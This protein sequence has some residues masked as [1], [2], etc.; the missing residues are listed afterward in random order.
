MKNKHSCS[1][2]QQAI[3]EACQ[4]AIHNVMSSQFQRLIPD[5][6][7]IDLDEVNLAIVEQVKTEYKTAYRQ[8]NQTKRP[9]DKP[10]KNFHESAL[11]TCRMTNC[12]YQRL[13]GSVKI[14]RT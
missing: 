3:I 7:D 13:S 8:Y 4:H 1:R 10:K 5:I 11:S 14:P 6:G 2:L 12:K 9:T